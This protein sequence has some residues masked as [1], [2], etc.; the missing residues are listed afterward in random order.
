M[1]CGAHTTGGCGGPSAGAVRGG[2]RLSG[3]G[4][5]VG[6]ALSWAPGV[7]PYLPCSN[8][9]LHEPSKRWTRTVILHSG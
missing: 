4:V 5:G 9:L 6:E 1:G 3:G 2:E 8:F 7:S